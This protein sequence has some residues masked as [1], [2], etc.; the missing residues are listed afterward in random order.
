[1]ILQTYFPIM[2]AIALILSS[3]LFVITPVKD[4]EDKLRYLLNFTGI[5]STAYYMG[6]FLADLILFIV[7]T[8]MI[9]ILS[10]VL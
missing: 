6:I 4:K 7:P 9:V 2:V 1:M 3:G 8:I 10:F 5:S